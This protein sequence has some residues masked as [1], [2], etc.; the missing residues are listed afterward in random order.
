MNQPTNDLEHSDA[1]RRRHHPPLRSRAL[2]V[3]VD[4]RGIESALRTFKRLIMK[5]GLLKELKRHAYFEKPGDRK[6]RKI[7]ES[8]RRQRRQARR[9]QERFGANHEQR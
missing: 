2:S 4:D 3:V 8:V 6:R 7:R 9:M 5:E 1:D